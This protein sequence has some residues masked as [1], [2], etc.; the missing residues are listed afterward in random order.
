MKVV[1][2]DPPSPF[3]PLAEWET[4]AAEME[5]IKDTHAGAAEHLAEA[6]EVIAQKKAEQWPGRPEL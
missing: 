2:I 3:A 1:L 5:K 6:Q 4:F